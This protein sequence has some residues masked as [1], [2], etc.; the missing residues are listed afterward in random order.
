MITLSSAPFRMSENTC[1]NFAG[2]DAD[3]IDDVAD[4]VGEEVF[5]F[6]ERRDRDAT[7]R[8]AQRA[9]HHIDRLGGF[10]VRTQHAA[11]TADVRTHAFEVAIELGSI[12]D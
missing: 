5:G 7:R 6:L 1:A 2:R 12:E 4:A 9:S 10:H 11:Q 3:G 8:V